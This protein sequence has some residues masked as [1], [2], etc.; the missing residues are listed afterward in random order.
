MPGTIPMAGFRT[1]IRTDLFLY[2]FIDR[3]LLC[4]LLGIYSNES[5]LRMF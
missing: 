5:D 4:W 2:S 3:H 1:K